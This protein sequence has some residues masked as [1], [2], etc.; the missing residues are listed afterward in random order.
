MRRRAFW[1][2]AAALCA[3][4]KFATER[5]SGFIALK[6][7]GRVV[8][9]FV[10]DEKYDKPFL[11][12]LTTPSG[13]VVSRGWPLEPRAGETADHPWHRG[14]FYGHGL[15]NGHD[16]WR[17]LGREKTSR[18]V[19]EGKARSSGSN[20]GG[21][22]A[23][24]PPT[25]SPIGSIDQEFRFSAGKDAWQMDASIVIAADRGQALT[26]G[27]TDDG[28]FAF[29]LSDEFRQDRGAMLRNSEGQET[30]EKIWGKPARW[31]H[32]QSKT[33]GVAMYDSPG[34]PR[35]P[36]GWHA[37]GYSL[38][39]ANPFAARAFSRDK[40]K[41]GSYTIAKGSKLTLRYTVLLHDGVWSDRDVEAAHRA[42]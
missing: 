2:A 4:P 39:S 35:Y 3:Y 17:E 6:A 21:R 15:V 12:P 20:F 34:N 41:D 37:R 42:G 29:R 19:L 10:F 11:Y 5:G 18:L 40:S 22:F 14:I 31:T 7:D 24:Q 1:G 8:T 25:G 13:L 33:A 27:D 36:T 28:G 32:Y 23:M 16:F 38:N 30:T 9:R 26:F